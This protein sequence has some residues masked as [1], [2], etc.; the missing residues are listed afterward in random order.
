VEFARDRESGTFNENLLELK[1]RVGDY[2]AYIKKLKEL[3]DSD[4]AEELIDELSS[5]ENRRLD[6]LEI[7]AQIFKLKSEVN[8][9]KEYRL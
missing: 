6:L 3:V 9:A 1:K 8:Q 2:E 4:K 5:N 7:K